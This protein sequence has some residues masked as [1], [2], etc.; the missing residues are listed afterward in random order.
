MKRLATI[1][2]AFIA[3]TAFTVSSAVTSAQPAEAPAQVKPKPKAKA[4]KKPAPKPA[5][6]YAD[7]APTDPYADPAAPPIATPAATKAAPKKPGKSKPG[8]P[9]DPYADPPAD[10]D[11]PDGKPPVDPFPPPIRPPTPRSPASLHPEPGDPMTPDPKA[12]PKLEPKLDAK[13]DPKA[14]STKARPLDPYAAPERKDDR[15]AIP[16]RVGITDATTMQGLLAVQR[17]DGW[18]LVDRDGSNPIARRLVAPEGHPTRPWFYLIPAK[19]SAIALV[20]DAEKRSFEHLPGSKLVY[21]GHRDMDKQLR[22]MLKGMRTVAVEYSMKAAVP[23]VSRVDAGTLELIRAV[24]VQVRSSDT[25]VQYTK[26]IWG[27]AGRTAHHVA[28]HHLVELRKEALAFIAKQVGAG[29]PVTEHDV[30]QRLVRGMTMRGLTGAPPIVAAGANTADPY[31]VP[32]AAKT[33]PIR[34]GDLLVLS[35]AAKLDKPDGI[36]A[37]QTWCAVVD[38]T[39]SH[40]IK[41]AFET[42]SLARDHALALIADRARKNRPVTG[43]EVDRATRAFIKKAGMADRVMHRT[44][45]S[46]DNDLQGGGADLDDFEVHDTRILTPGTGFTVGPGVYF[47]GQF[48]V[49]SEVSVYLSPSGPE[50]TTPAQDEVQPLLR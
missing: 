15:L 13:L 2:L 6:P 20:H 4:K 37:A 35:L 42:A 34:R 9:A 18:L 23:S 25:L 24:G 36:Y 50:I 12:D 5:D 47:A 48:G 21:Q 32:T 39:V 19:G 8:K 1:A 41:A 14:R 22:V 17:L 44:G 26:A 11:V 45:H 31:Y 29:V 30:Q 7:P 3:F 33:A 10:V 28:A 49:R 38:A 40:D 27:D 16:A 46:L 43:A